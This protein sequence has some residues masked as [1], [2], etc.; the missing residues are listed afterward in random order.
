MR[1]SETINREWNEWHMP[2]SLRG[3]D[4]VILVLMTWRGECRHENTCEEDE[5][6]GVRS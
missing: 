1:E 4:L 5:K 6:E 2:I 3:L